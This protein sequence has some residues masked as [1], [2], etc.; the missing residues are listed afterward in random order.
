M[1]T[2]SNVR[3]KIFGTLLF[4]L[5]FFFD[6]IIKLYKRK[7]VLAYGIQMIDSKNILHAENDSVWEFFFNVLLAKYRT[8]NDLKVN[9]SKW[10]TEFDSCYHMCCY[11][12]TST[13]HCMKLSS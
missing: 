4:F 2:E 7:K 13:I 1:K 8:V 11:M 10:N 9:V 6:Q 5:P 3:I 12:K